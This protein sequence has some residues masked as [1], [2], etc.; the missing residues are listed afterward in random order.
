VPVVDRDLNPRAWALA[1]ALR[2][3]RK[4]HG[5]SS[6]ELSNRLGHS[7]ALVS[8]WETGRR[9]PNPDRVAELLG[10]LGVT[11]E[12]HERITRL[13]EAAAEPVW[14]GAGLA[15]LPAH[16]VRA[17]DCERV[18]DAIV[19]WSPA[20][21]PELTRIPEYAR[22]QLTLAGASYAAT[23]SRVLIDGGRREIVNRAID[24]LPYTVLVGEAALGEPIGPPQVMVEQL[25]ALAATA[26][27]A[28]VTLQ[29][30]PARI[31]W[32]PGLAGAFTIYHFPESPEI[33]YF[34]HHATGIF[35][36]DPTDIA[37]HRSALETL[38]RKALSEAESVRRIIE[39]A[40]KWAVIR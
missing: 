27:R 23:E 6:R 36:S 32:H 10:E 30:L 3:I 24:P 20:T 40:R 39:T 14:F 9:T 13:A 22:A 34:P 1:T 37:H 4:Q 12:E 31:G 18:A 19:E 11:G 28:N 33:L 38:R 15:A 26:Q 25:N 35:V 16:I 29:I 2:R 8:H 17:I 5:I 7:H 21:I